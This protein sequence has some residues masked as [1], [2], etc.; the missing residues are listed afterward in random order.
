MGAFY[1][2]SVECTWCTWYCVYRLRYRGKPSTV[3]L[4]C[5][6]IGLHIIKLKIK[7]KQFNYKFK[8][9]TKSLHNIFFKAICNEIIPSRCS[10]NTIYHLPWTKLYNNRNTPMFNRAF[11][12]LLDQRLVSAPTW[13]FPVDAV[14]CPRISV[15]KVTGDTIEV[16]DTF[17]TSGRTAGADVTGDLPA[18]DVSFSLYRITACY[19]HLYL[20]LHSSKDLVILVHGVC[21][22]ISLC[23]VCQWTCVCCFCGKSFN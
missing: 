20:A 6:V 23:Y 4:L 13:P 16:T 7:P 8:Y 1:R 18:G 21:V 11:F 19:I 15:G 2:W 3:D 9:Y 22:W 5:T 10:L 17:R 12:S 14:R